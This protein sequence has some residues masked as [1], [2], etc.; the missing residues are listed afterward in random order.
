MHY[1]AAIL[2]AVLALVG[3]AQA[4]TCDLSGIS[5]FVAGVTCGSTS[6]NIHIL[7][8]SSINTSIETLLT[9]S[10]FQIDIVGNNSFEK[11]IIAAAFASSVFP[12]A[13]LNGTAFQQFTGGFPE[14]GA[15][16]AIKD[17]LVFLGICS[18]TQNCP[19][20]FGFVVINLPLGKNGVITANFSGAPPGT[21]FYGLGVT[22]GQ[23]TLL[24]PNSGAGIT[25]PPV[26][27][28]GTLALFATGLLGAAR[29]VRRKRES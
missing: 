13:T 8:G 29:L 18:S 4:N 23:I 6:D 25:A 14:Q 20:T 9:G 22:G 5:G 17:T 7:G 10:S 12:S 16:G 11:V 27:E 21:A 24:T 15:V 2:S 3:A 26:P 19:L 1:L 28:P